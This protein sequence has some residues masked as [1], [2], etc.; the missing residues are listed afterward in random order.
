M[1]AHFRLG[2]LVVSDEAAEVLYDSGQKPTDFLLRHMDG[3]YGYAKEPIIDGRR[4]SVYKTLSGKMIAI[5]TEA[6]QRKTS[7]FLAD[8]GPLSSE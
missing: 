2:E 6:D 7:I 5:V 8:D 4:V 1:A 3:D